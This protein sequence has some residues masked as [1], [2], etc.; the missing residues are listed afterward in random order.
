MNQIHLILQSKD[1]FHADVLG[2]ILQQYFASISS[3]PYVFDCNPLKWTLED[4]VGYCPPDQ[5]VLPSKEEIQQTI[6][7]SLTDKL[8]DLEDNEVVIVDHIPASLLSLDSD[9]KHNTLIQ[10]LEKD[11]HQVF[12]YGNILAGVSASEHMPIVGAS[13][14]FVLPEVNI[15][16]GADQ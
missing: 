12:L 11:G 5:F 6:V 10:R 8:D 15:S 1:E 9:I 2:H 7:D 14:D 13:P 16:E 3:H 4:L